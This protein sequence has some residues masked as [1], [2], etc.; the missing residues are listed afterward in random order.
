MSAPRRTVAMR[1]WPPGVET[2]F[3]RA[4]NP[5]PSS[6]QSL[7]ELFETI[8]DAREP[9]KGG[10]PKIVRWVPKGPLEQHRIDTDPSWCRLEEAAA[11]R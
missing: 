11:S 6:G 10:D 8:R 2:A 3:R 5:S 1:M 7:K 9:D 4:F